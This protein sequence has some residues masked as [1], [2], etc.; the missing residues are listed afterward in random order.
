ML[1]RS[2]QCS[3]SLLILNYLILQIIAPSH[4]KKFKEIKQTRKHRN[5][6]NISK[7]FMLYLSP[8]GTCVKILEYQVIKGIHRTDCSS[9][10]QN[11]NRGEANS[12][13]LVQWRQQDDQR[14]I[15]N[16]SVCVRGCNIAI[17]PLIII[18]WWITVP[19]LLSWRDTSHS[20]Q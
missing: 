11:A 6:E 8:V 16:V 18:H 12:I 14:V 17:L 1:Q 2:S 3:F 13:L 4:C 15:M 7:C 5:D 9:H 20:P 10:K 19:I